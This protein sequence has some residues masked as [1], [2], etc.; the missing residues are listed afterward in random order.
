MVNIEKN[1][2]AYVQFGIDEKIE[3]MRNDTLG[4]VLD[5]NDP[6]GSSTLANFPENVGNAGARMQIGCG[7]EL[8]A[9]G[10]MRVTR[11]RAEKLDPERRLERSAAGYNF[12]EDRPDRWLRQRAAA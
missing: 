12:S 7:A 6:E 10:K 5:R 2:R 11:L 8:L 4:R 3:S 9:R 1:L